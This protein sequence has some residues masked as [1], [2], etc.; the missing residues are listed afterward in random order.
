MAHDHHDH[1]HGASETRLGIATLLTGG[2]M[3]AEFAGGYISG[4]LALLADAGH[5]G[6]DF[7]SLALAFV[8]MRIARRPANSTWTYGYDRFQILVAFANGVILFFVAGWIIWEAGWRLMEPETVAGPLML[9]VATGGLAVN[10]IAFFVLHGADKESVNIRGALLHILGD[11]LG[12]VG[13]I[14]AAL[15]I[16]Y[17]GWTPIDPILSVFV[18]VIILGGAWRLVRD[19]GR[20]L[21]EAAPADM[22][23]SAIAP[24]VRAGVAI[25]EDVHHV[26]VWSITEKMQAVT[27]HAC[28]PEGTDAPPV[29]RQIK[30]VL[31]EKFGIGHATVEIEYGQCSD[32]AKDCGH[33][34]DHAHDHDHDHAGH[35]HDH[36]H[37]HG[38]ARSHARV[39]PA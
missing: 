2:F 34:H 16:I 19:S 25:V 12:S 21:L 28:V 6:I 5:M 22:D 1:S 39:Q 27:L 14:A 36:G 15:I 17:T 24:A 31:V 11:L 32:H 23:S 9:L 13:A 35:A 4:S 8:A 18:S 3:I 29:I 10:I 26:H 33:D 7:A 30:A 20:V 38:H 37:S